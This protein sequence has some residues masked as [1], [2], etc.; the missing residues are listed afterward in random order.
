MIFYF[1]GIAFWVLVFIVVTGIGIYGW[2]CLLSNVI[3]RIRWRNSDAWFVVNPKDREKYMIS[4]EEW[5]DVKKFMN[6]KKDIKED[7]AKK[8]GR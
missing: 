2:V 8:K 7:L 6:F 1:T 3:R 5:K 4:S